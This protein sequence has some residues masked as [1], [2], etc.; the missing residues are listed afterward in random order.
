MQG[1]RRRI[2][3][4]SNEIEPGVWVLVAVIPSGV[5]P[6]VYDGQVS[7]RICP[8]Q[9]RCA[10]DD[11]ERSN[12]IAFQFTV[13]STDEEDSSST[14]TSSPATSSPPPSSDPEKDT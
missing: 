3:V 11:V 6:G 12:Q 7:A 10:G 1:G 2:D 14:S 9:G 4:S 13:P 5:T 8:E